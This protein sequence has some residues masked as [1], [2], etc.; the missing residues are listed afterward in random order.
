LGSGN[1]TQNGGTLFRCR[2]DRLD[3]SMLRAINVGTGGTLVINL[4]AAPNANGFERG[5]RS[6]HCGWNCSLGTVALKF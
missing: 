1:L 3:P 5:E 2:Y 4:N 6:P